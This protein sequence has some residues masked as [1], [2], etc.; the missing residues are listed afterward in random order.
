[1]KDLPIN[2]ATFTRE[3]HRHLSF[4]IAEKFNKTEEN[5]IAT[6]LLISYFLK[7]PEFKEPRKIPFEIVWDLHQTRLV[8]YTEKA[9]KI[10]KQLTILADLYES[11]FERGIVRRF[12]ED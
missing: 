12:W 7:D 2:V 1:M 11:R 5:L 9:V 3:E 4:E 10:K 8:Y 6:K